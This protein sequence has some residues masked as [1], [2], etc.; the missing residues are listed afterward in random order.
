MTSRF[1]CK[2]YKR[3]GVE[4]LACRRLCA[5]GRACACIEASF[6]AQTE[7]GICEKKEEF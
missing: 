3:D 4:P 6:L 1:L 7:L 5:R 2:S